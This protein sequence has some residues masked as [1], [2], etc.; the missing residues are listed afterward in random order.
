M[1]FSYKLGVIGA[2]NMASAILGGATFSKA[3]EWSE[4]VIF[5]KVTECM[6]KFKENYNVATASSIEELM[7]FNPEFIL[8]SIKPQ[9][10][11]VLANQLKNYKLNNVISI[12]AGIPSKT[13]KEALNCNEVIRV[14]PNTPALV[15]EGMTVI[16]NTGLS[17]DSLSF[18]QKIFNSIGKTV[19]LDENQFDAVTAVSGSGPAYVYTFLDAMIKAGI[20]CGLEE[21]VSEQLAT[22]TF[23]G[24]IKMAEE[25]SMP[26]ETLI[27]NVTSKGG[28]TEQG[29]K[30]L[31]EANIYDTVS[32][33]VSAAKLR[34]E[35]LGREE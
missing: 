29:L 25:S 20:A 6:L 11:K 19:L 3:L 34:S 12:M 24:T 14:M 9:M 18:A 15:L 2:G 28:T 35:E 1:D 32:S 21:D 23:K 22:Q 16:A 33:T 31:R 13:I 7:D 8:L 27:D 4:V 30:V 10:F 17:D 5:D 26:L